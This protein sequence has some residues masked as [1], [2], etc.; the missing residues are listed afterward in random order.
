MQ[1]TPRYSIPAIPFLILLILLSSAFV[2]LTFA[3]EGTPYLPIDLTIAHAVQSVQ[4]PGLDALLKFVGWFGYPP[5]VN[6]EM[7]LIFLALW[8]LHQRW[9]AVSFAFATVG[10]AVVGVMFKLAVD[11]P[12]PSPNLI[13]VLNPALDGG[14]QSYP[15]GHVE[16]YIATLG[17]L[18]YMLWVRPVHRPWQT[19]LMIIL[20]G[21]ILLIGPSRIYVGEHWFSDV[22]GALLLGLIWLL[23]SIRL[24]EWGRGRV[25][26]SKARAP[27]PGA[28]RQKIPV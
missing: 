2:A 10:I 8:F 19:I 25:L 23:L 11:R 26:V 18:L 12:R 24:Y 15:A 22:L 28:E 20:G 5:Q 21:M 14:H 13:R 17:I 7:A 9:E 16:V 1:T 6:V 27:G 3:V 4:L